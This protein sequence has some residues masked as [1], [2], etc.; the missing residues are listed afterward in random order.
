MNSEIQKVLNGESDGCIVCADCLEVMADMP[1]GCVDAV[2]TDPPYGLDFRGEKWD[3]NI[4]DWFTDAMRVSGGQMIF[5]T[6]PTT[7]WD[8]PRPDWVFCLH[9]E[10]ANSRTTAGGFSHWTPVL[11]YGTWKLSP[12]VLKYH[13]ISH[14]KKRGFGHPSPKPDIVGSWLVLEAGGLIL[15]PFCGSGTTCVAAKK[16]GR[17]Y[18]GI[19]I[20]E[21]YCRIARNR[22]ANTEKPLFPNNA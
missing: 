10:A 18:I 20:D 22:I 4:P 1:D 3:A 6:G 14:A 17:K 15:D 13:A 9:R 19:D 16:M 11:A 5:T 12:D 21:K 2:V 8:Y 7:Q